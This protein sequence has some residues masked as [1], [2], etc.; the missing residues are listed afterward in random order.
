MSQCFIMLETPQDNRI[1]P[2]VDIRGDTL[3]FPSRE[4]AI[5]A[6]RDS[7]MA[8]GYGYEVYERQ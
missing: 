5:E 8:Q 4:A 7:M 3:L 6:A 1:I 2:M